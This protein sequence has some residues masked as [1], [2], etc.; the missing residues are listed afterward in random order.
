MKSTVAAFLASVVAAVSCLTSE[1]SARGVCYDPAHNTD[2]TTDAISAD[3]VVIKGSGFTGIR[4]FYTAFGNTDLGTLA[5]EQGLNATLG[6]PFSND[7][8]TAAQSHVDAAIATAI[9]YANETARVL[10]IFVGNENLA[11]VDEVPAEMLTYIQQIKAQVPENVEVGTVQRN[12]ELLDS[13]RMANIVG[14]V[15]LLNACDVV[16]VNIHP[17]F[18]P[19]TAADKAIDVLTAQWDTLQS[20][21]TNTTFPGLSD[22]LAIT[23]TGWPSGG[24]SN[25][26]T[27]TVAGAQTF[28]EDYMS[29]SAS[30][31]DD[32]RNFYF[33]MFDQP[34]RTDGVFEPYF[35]LI[36]ESGAAKFSLDS[37]VVSSS[38]SSASQAAY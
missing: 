38:S 10:Q 36:N 30:T 16:G 1:V 22:K 28:F 15:D 13:S 24:S 20:E 35:G 29:W 33:Q 34:Q 25:G 37:A 12:T 26:N 11:S 23:E 4:T 19:N 14:L 18:S 3:F 7:D 27:G 9:K 6:I 5:I 32:S 8:P 2:V 31:L 17:V 21:T